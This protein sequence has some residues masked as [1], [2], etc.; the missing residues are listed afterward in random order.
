MSSELLTICFNA[1]CDKCSNSINVMYMNNYFGNPTRKYIQY[2]VGDYIDS[3]DKSYFHDCYQLVCPRC[4]TKLPDYSLVVK[5][6][7]LLGV[8]KT[9]DKKKK[10]IEDY[11][12]IEE[13][14]FRNSL[15]A[16]YYKKLQGIEYLTEYSFDDILNINSGDKIRLMQKEFTVLE[17]FEVVD[18]TDDS[19]RVHAIIGSR[20]IL[21]RLKYEENIRL[22]MFAFNSNIDRMIVYLYKNEIRKTDDI[23]DGFGYYNLR[24]NEI[25]L[26]LDIY[27]LKQQIVENYVP[28]DVM[29]K[30]L[31]KDEEELSD[32]ALATLIYNEI[33]PLGVRRQYL[34]MLMNITKDSELKEQIRERLEYDD[35]AFSLFKNNNEGF[36]YVLVSY[37]FS[38]YDGETIGY[39]KDSIS[40]KNFMEDWVKAERESYKKMHIGDM[41][42]DFHE[43]DIFY[44]INKY[45]IIDR[46]K[47]IIKPRIVIS[48]FVEDNKSERVKET[49][50]CGDP[51]S[52]F[53]FNEK[54]RILYYRSYETELDKCIELEPDTP[55]RFEYGF[56]FFPIIFK[57]GERV[58]I[59]GTDQVGKINIG[60]DQSVEKFYQ[61]VRDGLYADYSDTFL[62]V[63]FKNGN[64]GH[65]C[66]IKLEK[67]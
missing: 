29:R 37:L 19:D 39:F 11:E 25:L 38:E 43:N 23:T 44:E 3:N 2:Y 31:L 10:I 59:C 63:D 18:I 4:G 15:Y 52:T 26:P 55:E 9:A 12:N 36:V 34:K 41:R 17:R 53:A 46:L 14:F 22:A 56:V 35:E 62:R 28:S 58:K 6:G 47:D 48:S 54:G 64:H 8:I 21:Y 5:K 27:L 7:Q 65:I 20:R 51:V 67:I 13:G 50:Y 16:D 57:D 32:R 45:Q 1:V 33:I 66:P 30:E 40:A 42:T 49:D 61:S 60:D 24:I